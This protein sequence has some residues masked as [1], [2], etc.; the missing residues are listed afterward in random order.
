MVTGKT[1][2]AKNVGKEKAGFYKPPQPDVDVSGENPEGMQ[3]PSALGVQSQGSG[4]NSNNSNRSGVMP[5]GSKWNSLLMVVAGVVLSVV[6]GMFIFVKGGTYTTDLTALQKITTDNT[7]KVDTAVKN[8]TGLIG[9]ANNKITDATKQ[10]GNSIDIK[11]ANYALKSDITSMQNNIDKLA[12][13]SDM[14]NS[15]SVLANK[16]DLSGL[17]KQ[18]VIFCS[19]DV[20]SKLKDY[21]VSKDL[22]TSNTRIDTLDKQVKDLQ[23]SVTK[24]VAASTPNKP[25][26]TGTPTST[27][28]NVSIKVTSSSGTI[29]PEGTY[30]FAGNTYKVSAIDVLAG[31]SGYTSTPIVRVTGGNGSGVSAR[32]VV[33]GGIV[34]GIIVDNGGDG[35]LNR[36]SVLQVSLIGGGCTISAAAVVSTMELTDLTLDPTITIKITNGENYNISNLIFDLVLLADND[37]PSSNVVNKLKLNGTNASFRN[38]YT[39]SQMFTFETSGSGITIYANTTKYIYI[40]PSILLK[41][42]NTDGDINFDVS[43]LLVDFSRS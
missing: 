11:M 41:N 30:D 8:V 32:A 15:I 16:N 38:T 20:D 13:K 27:I 19:A 12:S 21:A 33:A 22:I 18:V 4:N 35:Y 2:N 36:P 17:A 14:Q 9:D 25:V 24:L 6:I 37:V 10:M 3:E 42:A 5:K 26:N 39:D 43:A 29:I 7:A 34:T 40:T 23:D 1:D 28:G 31:G